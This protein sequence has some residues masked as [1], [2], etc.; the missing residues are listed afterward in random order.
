MSTGKS[1]GPRR[2][3]G[4]S[5]LGS[6][7]AELKKLC[8]IHDLIQC[9]VQPTGCFISSGDLCG[10]QTFFSPKLQ[11]EV[12]FNSATS[13][14]EIL[15]MGIQT[16]PY[17]PAQSKICATAQV[18]AFE[19]VTGGYD[20]ATIVA[21]ILAAN[22]LMFD[23]AGNAVAVTADDV[24]FVKVEPKACGTLTSAGVEVEIDYINV[25]GNA[26]SNFVDLE[27]GGVE[28]A[29]KIEVPAGGCAIVDVCFGKCWSKQEVAAL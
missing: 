17:Q 24:N 5:G 7:Q 12:Y 19:L 14:Y 28:G 18:A 4:S 13:T 6:S 3:L 21:D 2:A 20:V 26:A 29:T 16:T 11:S 15:P 8:Q 27:D 1:T 25:N 22:P 9:Q 23:V 10:K